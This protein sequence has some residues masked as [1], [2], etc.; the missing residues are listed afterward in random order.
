[1]LHLHGLVLGPTSVVNNF[2]AQVPGASLGTGQLTG[3][4]ILRELFISHCFFCYRDV[5]YILVSLQQ[6]HGC[7]SRFLD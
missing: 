3:L 2:Y 1:M 5:I 4:W 7:C 6:Q